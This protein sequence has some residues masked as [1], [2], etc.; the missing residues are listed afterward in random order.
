MIFKC[1]ISSKNDSVLIPVPQYPLYASTVELLGGSYSPY[2][3][4]ENR[5]WQVD[6]EELERSINSAH[7]KG[8]FVRAIVVVNPGNPT[9]SLLS[10]TSLQ[11]IIRFANKHKLLIIAD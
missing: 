5:E 9:G 2:Y 4:K 10:E 7:R 1:L 11:Q 8:N 3:L 6:E